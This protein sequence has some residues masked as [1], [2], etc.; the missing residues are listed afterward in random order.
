MLTNDSVDY[1]DKTIYNYKRLLHGCLRPE[2]DIFFY[3]LTSQGWNPS[4]WTSKVYQHL[5]KGL[6]DQKR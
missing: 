4:I 5:I 6:V 3:N 1:D 2:L